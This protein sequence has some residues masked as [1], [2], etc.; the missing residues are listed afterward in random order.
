MPPPHS[1]PLPTLPPRTRPSALHTLLP[2]PLL[3]PLIALAATFLDPASPYAASLVSLAQANYFSDIHF[4]SEIS[5][6]NQKILQIE[7]EIEKWKG[8]YGEKR[9]GL[10]GYSLAG[11]GVVSEETGGGLEDGEYF[12]EQSARIENL[13]ERARLLVEQMKERSEALLR[14]IF[15]AAVGGQGDPLVMLRVMSRLSD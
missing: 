2:A 3:N 15:S 11:E 13:E 12:A 10:G 4:P 9:A 6:V 1:I 5:Q 7:E 8:I 14:G